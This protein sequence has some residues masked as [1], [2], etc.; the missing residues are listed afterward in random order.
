MIEIKNRFTGEVIKKVYAADLRGAN[1]RGANLWGADLKEANLEFHQFPSIR[2]LSSMNLGDL[3]PELSL[4]LMRRDAL[5]HPNPELFDKWA[6]GGD[7]PYKDVERFWLFE[8]K[9]NIWS[10]GPPQ[11]TDRDL[12]L[13]ICKYKGWGI[14][15]YLG[16]RAD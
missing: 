9:R 3:S 7:C 2:L 16:R 6:A 15:G 14:K 10:P 5:A 13:A 12:I 11:M 4:E 8:V 1:L